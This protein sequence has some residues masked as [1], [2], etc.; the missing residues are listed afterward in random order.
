MKSRRKIVKSLVFVGLVLVFALSLVPQVGAQDERGG[1]KLGAHN[2]RLKGEYAVVGRETCVVHW[3][4]NPDNPTNPSDSV[5]WTS[6]STMVGTAIYNGDGTGSAHVSFVELVQPIY[7]PIPLYPIWVE[8]SWPFPLPPSVLGHTVTSD[9]SIKYSYDV[10][11]D[12]A[13]TRSI[14]PNTA[15]GIITSGD[16]TGN[17]FAFTP[18]T[19]QGFV[20][21]NGEQILYSNVPG[22][23]DLV[24]VEIFNEDG[25][26]YG[27]EEQECVRS[28]VLTLIG[29]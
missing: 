20:S 22:Q 16:L 10:S 4:V 13:I 7:T 3:L 8:P 19:L 17:T 27:R 14:T 1:G 25:S 18:F 24:K 15:T 5:Y 23:P 6:T 9:I 12:G 11:A 28:R 21:K 29:K 26:L 2:K